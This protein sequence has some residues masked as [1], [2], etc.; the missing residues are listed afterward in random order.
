ML[1]N[2]VEL[3]VFT[4]FTPSKTPK[5]QQHFIYVPMRFKYDKTAS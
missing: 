5:K 4:N 3:F 2:T 1:K